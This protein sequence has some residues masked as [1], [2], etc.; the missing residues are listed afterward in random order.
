MRRTSKFGPFVG[1]SGY[2]KCRYI[3][4]QEQPI[5][6]SFGG[7]ALADD[8]ECSLFLTDNKNA[9]STSNAV[10]D[11]IYDRL[12]LASTGRALNHEPRRKTRAKHSRLLRRVR[13]S[14]EVTFSLRHIGRC[15][16]YFAR[17]STY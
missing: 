6:Q 8:F 4:K 16:L 1:C 7:Q 11:D 15:G 10:A 5:T 3:L 9:F 12:A 13:F 2:P 14:S 17:T